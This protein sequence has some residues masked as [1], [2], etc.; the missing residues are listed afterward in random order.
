MTSLARD[1]KTASPTCVSPGATRTGCVDFP[2]TGDDPAMRWPGVGGMRARARSGSRAN[3]GLGH[4]TNAAR[5]RGEKGERTRSPL[6]L[7]HFAVH[8]GGTVVTKKK[9][10]QRISVVRSGSGSFL[11]SRDAR[12]PFATGTRNGFRSE[13]SRCHAR[14]LVRTPSLRPRPLRQPAWEQLLTWQPR[15]CHGNEPAPAHQAVRRRPRLRAPRRGR[16]QR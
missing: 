2:G 16:P 3:A 5:A 6:S 14:P 12:G 13:V 7:A 8:H 9:I 10:K 11:T 1:E 15:P 4:A